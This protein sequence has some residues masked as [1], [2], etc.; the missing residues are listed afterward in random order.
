MTEEDADEPDIKAC[1][2]EDGTKGWH[3]SE[4]IENWNFGRSSGRMFEESMNLDTTQL[5]TLRIHGCIV[6]LSS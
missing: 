6:F 4:G 1:D 2:C 3:M 5:Y